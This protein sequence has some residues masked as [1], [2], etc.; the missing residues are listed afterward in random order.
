MTDVE[1][2][3]VVGGGQAGG[4]LVAALRAAGYAGQLTLLGAEDAYPYSRPPLS[5]SYLLGESTADDLLIRDKDMYGRQQINVRL[6]TMVTVID[7][8]ARFVSLDTGEQVPYTTLVLATG[9]RPR[10]LP[11][12]ELTGPDNVLYVRTRADIDRL[13]GR[14]APGARLVIVGGGY[15]GLEVASVARRTGLDVTVLEA[16]PRVL[17]RV[18]SP[19]VSAFF[20]RVHREEGVGIRTGVSIEGF[21]RRTDG[22][23]TAVRLD[24]G[25]LVPCDLL[26]VGIGLIPNTE[27]AEAAGLEVD[28]G[29]LVNEF[30]RT[31]DPHI[32]AIGDVARFPYAREGAWRR[33]ESVPNASDQAHA[34]A[35]TLVG[36][37]CA[38]DAV[39]WFWSNQYD[40]KLQA[41]GLT[42]PDHTVVVRGDLTVGR[43]LAVFYLEEGKVVAADVAGS[44][45][46]F[47][48]AKKLVARQA[49]VDPHSLADPAISLKTLLGAQL[50]ATPGKDG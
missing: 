8:Q 2:I 47:A 16:A 24:G 45:P 18:T 41:I 35:A 4:E 20:E 25:A 46:D 13:R 36:E 34:L 33:L 32:Y 37:M 49:D 43:R 15:I 19:P 29:I 40:V 28:D 50:A 31:K 23:V 3:V 14:F 1:R 27:L 5:K 17:S 11:A 6:R 30:L 22:D 39:P 10:R 21:D 7:R 42:R 9:G 38:Y 48:M 12:P 26:L 44:P